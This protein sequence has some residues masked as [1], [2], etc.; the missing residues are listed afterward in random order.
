M[1]RA[2]YF[3]VHL[4]IFFTSIRNTSASVWECL[5]VDGCYHIFVTRMCS[6]RQA[7]S[8]E[9]DPL[10][11]HNLHWCVVCPSTLP[12]WLIVFFFRLSCPGLQ[13]V[14]MHNRFLVH[15]CYIYTYV[16]VLFWWFSFGWWLMLPEEHMVWRLLQRVF[17]SHVG[18][19]WFASS[20][21]EFRH[22]N[23]LSFPK[24]ILK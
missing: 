11:I 7:T 17:S 8:T 5:W 24:A 21:A 23:C 9:V 3:I 13:H 15:C 10:S 19:G 1:I 22:H 14:T 16:L 18:L 12:F 6:D 20:N 4:C 2:S